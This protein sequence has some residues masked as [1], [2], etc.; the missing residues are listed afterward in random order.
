MAAL[1][2]MSVP[3]LHGLPWSAGQQDWLIAA[4]SPCSYASALEQPCHAVLVG[5]GLTHSCYADEPPSAER[6]RYAKLSTVTSEGPD[7]VCGLRVFVEIQPAALLLP[8]AEPV[9][10]VI[11]DHCSA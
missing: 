6:S 3:A 11:S 1:P 9:V 7:C 2:Q 8:G 4:A 5:Q 10:D